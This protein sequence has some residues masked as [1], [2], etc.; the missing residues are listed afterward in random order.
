[1]FE[2]A[3]QSKE[4]TMGL[5]GLGSKRNSLPPSPALRPKLGIGVPAKSP[6][7]KLD[8]PAGLEVSELDLDD[9][10]FTSTFGLVTT[11]FAD[12]AF[13]PD[14]AA[15]DPWTKRLRLD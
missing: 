8:R 3:A 10:E 6:A 12:T 7:P 9:E 2:R 15:D 4:T 14:D 1:M 13:E 11:Q 5:F